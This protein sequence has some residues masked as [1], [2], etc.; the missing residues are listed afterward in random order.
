[1][2]PPGR[3]GSH[4]PDS[5]GQPPALRLGVVDDH[6]VYR[7]GL[8]SLLERI[9]GIE[10]GWDT[11]SVHDAIAWCASDPVQAVLMDLNLGGP[12][13]GLQATRML[14]A[15]YRGLRVVLMSGLADEQVLVA[16]RGV[17]AVGFL[18][19]ELSASDMVGALRAL[20]GSEPPGNRRTARRMEPLVDGL[21]LVSRVQL[22]TREME[23]LREIRQGRTNREIADALGVSTTTVNKHVHSLFRKLG[24]RNR[25]QAAI[26]A[27]SILSRPRG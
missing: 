20:V 22:S 5:E 1:M 25:S 10:I 27:A 14:V 9:E 7:L 16:A 6:E 19:K 2:I 15:R 4:Q 3:F 17:G 8:K 26:V 24:V 18:P 23:V 12:L 13:D 21:A 11:G